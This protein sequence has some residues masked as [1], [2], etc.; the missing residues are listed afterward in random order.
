[1]F[2]F[3]GFKMLQNVC[4]IYKVRTQ[5]A[6]FQINWSWNCIKNMSVWSRGNL[7]H[8]GVWSLMCICLILLHWKAVIMGDYEPL[9]SNI[10][11]IC[12]LSRAAV[13]SWTKLGA[14]IYVKV[15]NIVHFAVTSFTLNHILLCQQF[16]L[17]LHLVATSRN[18]PSRVSV[19]FEI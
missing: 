19:T 6:L 4:S 16:S 18:K 12:N 14:L 5:N 7:N 17:Y 9:N 1:M 15:N 13:F 3:A 8:K 2:F 10:N 11:C